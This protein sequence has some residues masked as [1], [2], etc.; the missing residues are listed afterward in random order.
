MGSCASVLVRRAPYGTQSNDVV[1][2]LSSESLQNGVP[3]RHLGD[4]I[5]RCDYE[6]SSSNDTRESDHMQQ[7]PPPPLPQKMIHV[8]CVV[9]FSLYT[10]TDC[11]SVFLLLCTFCALTVSLSVFLPLCLFVALSLCC[12]SFSFFLFVS[13]SLS[14]S[15]LD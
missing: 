2:L 6:W 5:V 3:G 4:N 1:P 7:L 11:L 8:G 12:L 9:S 14:L 13:L 10:C 15:Q